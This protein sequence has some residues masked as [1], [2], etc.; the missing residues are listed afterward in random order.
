MRIAVAPGDG[1]GPE[2]I[3]PTVRILKELIPDLETVPVEV[4][5]TRWRRE[6]RAIAPEDFNVI[7][8]CGCLLFGAITTPPDPDYSSVVVRLR[9]EL[10]L[11]ANIRPVKSNPLSPHSG[12]DFVVVRENL[13]G[14]YSG[15]E[16][17]NEEEARTTRVITRRG[18]ERIARVAC[19]HTRERLTIVHK[20]NVLKSC[21]LFRSVCREVAEE[22]QVEYDEV[23]VDV[24]AY[25]LI[26]DPGRFDV[27]VASNLFG[28]ILSDEAAGLVGGLGLCPSANVGDDYGMFEPVHGSAPDIAGQGI[29]NPIGAILSAAMLLEWKGRGDEAHRVREAVDRALEDGYATPDLGGKDSTEEVA[30][31]V[32]DRL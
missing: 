13:E 31:A 14:L 26:R 27:I 21:A 9:K 15:V 16:E 20:A 1:I 32:L 17:I 30:N 2:I 29:A 18:T 22:R 6:G 19:D 12:V 11:Y 10:D 4:G 28:D 8:D 25:L 24:A 23:L 5:L 7:R 3:P